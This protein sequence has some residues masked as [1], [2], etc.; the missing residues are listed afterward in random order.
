MPRRITNPYGVL[1]LDSSATTADIR[2]AYLRLAKKYHP[3]KNPGDK[4][5][6]WIFREIQEAYEA[7]RDTNEVRWAEKD[8]PPATQEDDART[9]GDHARQRAQQAEEAEREAYE[10]WERPQAEDARRRWESERTKHTAHEEGGTEPICDDCGNVA[11][12]WSRLPRFVRTSCAWAKWTLLV[13]FSGLVFSLSM[14]IIMA[15]LWTVAWLTHVVVAL[16]IGRPTP[17][18]AELPSDVLGVLVL[19]FVVAFAMGMKRRPKACPRCSRV[20]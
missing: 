4:A 15:F 20:S 7:L 8:R 18:M 10:R 17:D 12:W 3:D 1:G 19:G 6:E 2:T 5:S 14:L 11:R 13:C 9:R 16:L